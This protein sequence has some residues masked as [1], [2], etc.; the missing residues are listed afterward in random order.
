MSSFQDIGIEKCH[1]SG[2]CGSTVFLTDADS[3][4]YYWVKIK[5]FSLQ[6][7][8]PPHIQLWSGLVS[9]SAVSSLDW[10]S[11]ASSVFSEYT[12]PGDE[13]LGIQIV[14]D[15]HRTGDTG[16]TS[17]EEHALLKRVLLAYARFNKSI[18]YCQGFNI[19]A[20]LILKVVG[21]DELLAL[22]IMIHVIDYILPENYF[23]QNLYAL[24]VDMAAFRELLKHTL[25]ELSLHIENL[26]RG[27]SGVI[28][29][30]YSSECPPDINSINAYEPPLADVFTMQWFLTIFASALPR[31]AT[32]RVWDL[33][34]LEGSEML[35]HTGVAIMAVMEK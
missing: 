25:P 33:M 11:I 7:S 5:G 34:F 22:K 32:R 9:I 14:K 16:F 35:L 2:Y 8:T 26:Q 27:A 17:S 29:K 23:A 24:S 10:P 19:L 30:S 31:K 1:I 20:A 13:A 6:Y 12:M 28:K 15:L 21:F 18:G 3:S 4:H